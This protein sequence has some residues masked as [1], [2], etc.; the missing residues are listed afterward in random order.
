[1]TPSSLCFRA[2]VLMV[3]AGMIWGLE[4][5]IS[6]D[7]STFPAHA[8][9]NLLGFVGLFLIGFFYR[10]HPG[11]EASRLAF[12]QIWIWILGTLV[13]VFGVGLA[14]SGHPNGEIFAGIGAFIVLGAAI[15]FAWLVFKA[16]PDGGRAA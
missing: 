14:F 1:M 8:H 3:L 7:H 4:M 6:G 12:P 10:L 11:V 15:L 2:G 9:L 5:G 16:P 13:M